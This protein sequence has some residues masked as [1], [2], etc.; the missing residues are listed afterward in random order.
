MG[1]VDFVVIEL[2]CGI[3]KVFLYLVIYVLFLWGI[4]VFI[5]LM[6][7]FGLREGKRRLVLLFVCVEFSFIF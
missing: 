2:Y 1:V 5:W 4:I 7:K 6:R 3:D